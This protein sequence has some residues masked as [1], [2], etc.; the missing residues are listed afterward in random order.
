MIKYSFDYVNKGLGQVIVTVSNVNG[1]GSKSDEW[2]EIKQ[3]YDCWYLS[4]CEPI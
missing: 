4:L 3:C 2:D 1:G